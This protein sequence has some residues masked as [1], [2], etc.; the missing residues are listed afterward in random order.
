M[1]LLGSVPVL[2]LELPGLGYSK[3]EDS[4]IGLLGVLRGDS[5]RDRVVLDEATHTLLLDTLRVRL[6]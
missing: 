5:D 4:L 3:G 1:M 2:G 6:V